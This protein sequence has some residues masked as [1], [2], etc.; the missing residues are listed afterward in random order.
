MTTVRRA[1]GSLWPGWRAGSILW[2]ADL[3]IHLP[4]RLMTDLAPRP[5]SPTEIVDAA[6]QL[7][8]REP[9]QFVLITAI[10]NVP[11]LILRLA[12]NVGVTDLRGDA[13]ATGVVTIV[14]VL[15]YGIA[16]AVVTRLARDVYLGN[17]ADAGQAVRETIGRLPA[18]LVATFFRFLIV[19]VGLVLLI[20]PG[21]YALTRFF[22]V[23]Q[24][25]VLEG[26]GVTAAF[27]RS[28]RL[29]RDLKGHI[30]ITLALI[31]FI[32]LLVS[33]GVGFLVA[34]IAVYVPGQVVLQV[35][36]TAL[37]MLVYPL[38]GIT[39]TVLYYDARIRREGFD[40]ELLAGSAGL[41]PLPDFPV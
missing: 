31:W 25:I 41:T 11:L 18:L 27:E 24:A 6:L 12:L 10:A 1:A 34:F 39:E 2:S 8:R 28:A 5:R 4:A 33:I 7:Y 23:S 35:V 37:L 9:A 19:F 30:L 20:A 32:Y 26:T 22:A 17:V 36:S 3:R 21:L 29:S 15:T 16:V 40:V 38:F 14:S 13:G